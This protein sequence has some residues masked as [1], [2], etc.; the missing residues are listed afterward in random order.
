[1]PSIGYLITL[2]HGCLIYQRTKETSYRNPFQTS[3][4]VC[5]KSTEEILGEKPSKYLVIR[6]VC[7]SSLVLNCDLWPANSGQLKLCLPRDGGGISLLKTRSMWC[8]LTENTSNILDRKRFSTSRKSSLQIT[9]LKR[10]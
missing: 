9:I 8:L 5:S 4:C 1:M 6:I 2:K 10:I 3:F 7:C